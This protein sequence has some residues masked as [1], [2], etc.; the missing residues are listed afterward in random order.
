[1]PIF[2]INGLVYMLVRVAVNVTMTIQPFYLELVPFFCPM[3]D[4]PTS[5]ALALVPLISYTTQILFTITAQPTM[6]RR[7]KGITS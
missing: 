6:N 2:Y 7:L 1:M 5:R 4:E 3:A